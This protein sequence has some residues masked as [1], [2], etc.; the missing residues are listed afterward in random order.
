MTISIIH[1]SFG[2]PTQS[3]NVLDYWMQRAKGKHEYLVA[4]NIDDPTL[5]KYNI[6]HGAKEVNGFFCSSVEAIN[7][8]AEQATGDLMIVVS[9]DQFCPMNWDELILK[10]VAG[11]RDFVLKVYDGL[12]KSLITMPIFDRTYL[13][14]DGYVYFPGY[15]HLFCDT[16]YSDLAYMRRRVIVRNKLVF[17]HKQYSIVGTIPDSTA[18]RNESTYAQGKALYQSRKAVRFG[19]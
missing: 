17:P 4:L 9:D 8:T 13:N 7:E 16:E 3:G 5:N 14:R 15:K 11:Q 10:E 12:Q 18:L 6:P 19:E 1:P 2:R